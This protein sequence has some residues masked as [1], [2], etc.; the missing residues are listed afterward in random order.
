MSA[1]GKWCNCIAKN[2]TRGNQLGGIISTEPGDATAFDRSLP[3]YAAGTTFQKVGSVPLESWQASGP[4]VAWFLASPMTDPVAALAAE[5]L[6]E[7][8]YPNLNARGVGNAT[9]AIFQED[10]IAEV[11]DRQTIEPHWKQF[12][13][14]AGYT[15][16]GA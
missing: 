4:V 1:Y 14:D 10:I 8:P 12:I 5:F 9:I 16:P 15:F 7:G 2:K 13:L 6:S 3:L 11:G